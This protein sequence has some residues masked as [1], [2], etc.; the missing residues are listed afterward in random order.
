MPIQ[1]SLL[2]TIK[3]CITK[4]EHIVLDP[5]LVNECQNYAC[6]Q[7]ILDSKEENIYCYECKNKHEKTKFL[8]APANIFAEIIKSSLNELFEYVDEKLKNSFESLTSK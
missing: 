8:N 3:C 5:L 7:C 4:D 6:K 1:E 2:K